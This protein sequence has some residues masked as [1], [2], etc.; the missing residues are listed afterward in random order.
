MLIR[1][2]EMVHTCPEFNFNNGV[3]VVME[4]VPTIGVRSPLRL[5]FFHTNA[6][7]LVG[8]RLPMLV[9]LVQAGY[10]VTALAPDMHGSVVKRLQQHGIFGRAFELS[11]SGINPLR[12]MRDTMRLARILRNESPDIVF[13]NNIK[14]VVFVTIAA[15][16]AGIRRRFALVGGL[17]YAFTDIPNRRR[18]FSRVMTRLIASALYTVAFRLCSVV[19]FH[20]RDDLQKLVR[21]GICP[22]GVG[23]VVS[24]S[25]VDIKAFVPGV[26]P[27]SP[28][29]IFVG[30]LLADK[31][32]RE[33]LN[34]VIETKRTFPTAR[35]IL[36][37]DTDDN[38]SAIDIEEVR[39]CVGAGALEWMGKVTDVREFLRQSSVFVLPSYRE[40]VPRSTLE[41][42]ACGLA[43]ITTDA[44]GCRETVE[45][46]VNGILV[47]VGDSKAL[48]EAMIA[49]CQDEARVAQMGNHSRR[50]A[51]ARFSSIQVNNNI[52][53]LINEAKA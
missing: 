8:L 12:D 29:F 31:G 42:M 5:Y 3:S 36:V 37:G 48:T 21:L 46:G 23:S 40:G 24:G 27:L 10:E 34:A 32:V 33:Y 1:G 38:P 18:T 53:A 26:R 28:T 2:D 51:I 6:N 43:V 19:I 45:P 35:F 39:H 52:L 13:S 15:A 7:Y 30:R 9:A 41:A 16:I 17:G 4:A 20:N 11:P 22:A 49:L 44:P 14:P 25:G 47:P 50:I